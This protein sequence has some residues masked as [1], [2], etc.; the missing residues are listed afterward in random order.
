MRALLLAALAA[1]GAPAAPPA[2]DPPDPDLL[3]CV[4]QARRSAPKV[5]TSVQDAGPCL[6]VWFYGPTSTWSYLCC[7]GGCPRKESHD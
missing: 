1:C 3:T 4:Q 2:C 6:R 5:H 7:A